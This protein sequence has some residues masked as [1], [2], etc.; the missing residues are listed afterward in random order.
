MQCQ[1]AEKV[2][3]LVVVSQQFPIFLLYHGRQLVQVAN[4]QQLHSAEGLRVVTIAPQHIV[5]RIEQIRP[6][7]ADF[8]DYQ[9]FETADQADF[10]P[11]KTPCAIGIP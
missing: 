5:D 8:I 4:H 2:W 6:H 10:V 11:G 1:T 3:R 9:Q 7:H